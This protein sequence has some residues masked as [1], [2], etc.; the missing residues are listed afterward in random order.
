MLPDVAANYVEHQ[1]HLADVLLQGVIVKVDELL[2][3]E[4]ECRLPVGGASGADDVSTGLLR[5]LGDHRTDA[6][7]RT[8]HEDTL[9]RLELTMYEQSLPRGQ[10]R[11][12]QAR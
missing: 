6:T 1:V 10:A 4:A 3:T 2:C 8:V 5:E 7:G 9:T 12:R 11:N